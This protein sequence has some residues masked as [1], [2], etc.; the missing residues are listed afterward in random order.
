MKS[1]IFR[2]REIELLQYLGLTYLSLM[3]YSYWRWGVDD[4]DL[5]HFGEGEY[6]ELISQCEKKSNEYSATFCTLFLERVEYWERELETLRNKPSYKDCKTEYEQICN[7]A[8]CLLCFDAA[9]PELEEL[10]NVLEKKDEVVTQKYGDLATFF[11]NVLHFEKKSEERLEEISALTRKYAPRFYRILN[12]RIQDID[13][14]N[15]RES[16]LATIKRIQ[17]RR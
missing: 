12:H 11:D 15:R 6:E 9:D 16:I 5:A 17:G 2:K 4:D 13:F 14:T 10:I 1:I 7:I 3:E 8:I